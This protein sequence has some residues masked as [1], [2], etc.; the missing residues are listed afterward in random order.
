MDLILASITSGQITQYLNLSILVFVAFGLVGFVIGLIKGF[1]TQ[2][3][4]LICYVVMFVA[5][6]FL[7]KPISVWLFNY[8]ITDLASKI[9]AVDSLNGA[10]TIG[11]FVEITITNSLIEAGTTPSSEVIDFAAGISLSVIR[12]FLYFVFLFVIVILGIVLIP[13]LYLVF[14]LFIPKRLRKRKLRLLGGLSGFVEFVISSCMFV[15]PLTAVVNSS[16]GKIRDENGNIAKNQEIDNEA[17]DLVYNLVDGYN[18]SLMAKVLFTLSKEGNSLDV[19]MMDYI[20]S[21]KIGEDSYFHL[22]N[23]IG[24]AMSIAYDAIATGAFELTNK[25]IDL[26]ILVNSSFIKDTLYTL[27]ESS[28]VLF[29][30]PLI[31]SMGLSSSEESLNVDMSSIDLSQVDWSNSLKAVGDVFDAIKNTGYIQTMM[32]SSEN[33]LDEMFLSQE[34]E[35]YLKEAMSILGDS[36]LFSTLLPQVVV[37]YLKSSKNS[38][39]EEVSISRKLNKESEGEIK[40]SIFNELPEKAYD[41]ETYKDIAWGKELS[42][43]VEIMFDFSDQIRSIEGKEEISIKYLFDKL[44]SADLM[45]LFLGVDNS[46]TYTSEEQFNDNVFINGGIHNGVNIVGTKALLGTTDDTTTGLLDLQISSLL[47]NE[48]N[49]MPKFVKYLFASFV[50]N[51]NLV[52]DSIE[53]SLSKMS[54]SDWKKE[55]DSVLTLS[56]PI[57]VAANRL[58]ES[59]DILKS[60]SQENSEIK[61]SLLY[62]SHNMEKS[63]IVSEVVPNVIED[64]ITSAENMPLFLNLK[65]SDLN[66]TD[67]SEDT[68]FGDEFA[69]L[70]TDVL[71]ETEE[72]LGSDSF[73]LAYVVNNSDKVS[74]LL[75]KIYES[76]IINNP[77]V[78]ENNNF[79]NIMISI[80]AP[81][82]EGEDASQ[83]IPAMTN[84]L[85]VI[86]KNSI[87]G[88]ED[89]TNGWVNEN[90]NGEIKSLFNVIGSIAKDEND[91]NS[92]SYLFEY[93][94]NPSFNINDHLYEMG[95]EIERIFS[96]VD[97]SVLMKEALPT[98]LNKMFTTNESF[99]G[100]IDFN[101]VESFEEEGVNLSKT[102]SAINDIKGTSSD[103]DISVLIRGCDENLIKEYEFTN[104]KEEYTTYEGSYAKYFM[105]ESKSYELLNSINDTQ[106]IDLQGLLYTTIKKVFDGST[107]VTPEALESSESDFKFEKDSINYNES[108][109]VNWA[110]PQNSDIYYGEIYNLSRVFVY[111]SSINDLTSLPNEQFNE[112]LHVVMKSYPLRQLVGSIITNGLNQISSGSDS[113]IYQ[114]LFEPEYCDYEA[115]DRM[116]YVKNSEEFANRF[117]EEQARLKEIESIYTLYVNSKAFTNDIDSVLSLTDGG[118]SSTLSTILFALHNSEIF[119]SSAFI[120]IINDSSVRTKLTSFENL[121]TVLLNK[122]V[123]EG[124]HDL[125]YPSDI[126]EFNNRLSN[127]SSTYDRWLGNGSSDIGEIVN[128]NN[129]I[130]ELNKITDASSVEAILT[131]AACNF[132]SEL[133]RKVVNR[134]VARQEIKNDSGRRIVGID[135]DKPNPLDRLIY[136]Y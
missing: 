15:A 17:Y 82:D 88:I 77:N 90:G 63:V 79:E 114:A 135:F 44:Q 131:I 24:S 108:I 86:E 128:F 112:V 109:K 107:L 59:D 39:Q 96:K 87:L 115:I 84:N 98:T 71:P 116:D 92:T 121:F 58:S 124:L 136:E 127:D 19:K 66:F 65:V 25:V 4:Y 48:F 36:S 99:E 74:S 49:L 78:E 55:L 28:L 103:T 29:A 61:T 57:V 64:M 129:D 68:S 9:G 118:K 40:S 69:F 122:T 102:L 75:E 97:E 132:E 18:N 1:W 95:N 47:F 70:L 8:N 105:A 43:I 120:S 13:L 130:K 10:T 16:V 27:S 26:N 133:I 106:S 76:E 53:N 94:N 42:S 38:T 20:T 46:I 51:E 41:V 81:L 62:V 91:Q 7:I 110:C 6:I 14:R 2:T 23:E 32:G 33:K 119:N 12:F 126:Y 50:Q 83:N 104:D 35:A 21:S 111:S 37:S 45:N 5:M 100:F 93:L 60:L 80:F 123:N 34:N 31:T 56:V 72:I 30:L 22:Y 89:S 113:D 54:F 3:F 117:L 134:Y 85:F 101:K 11:E 73:S 67:F 52:F 125:I